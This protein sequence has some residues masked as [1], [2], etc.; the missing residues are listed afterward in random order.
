MDNH[1]INMHIAAM[2]AAL[3]AGGLRLT[4]SDDAD[5][6]K[7]Y[8][9]ANVENYPVS[10]PLD[11]ARVKMR[12]GFIW[13]RA[14]DKRGFVALECA[15]QIKAPAKRGGLAALLD[16]TTF[17]GR[18]PL[19]TFS[20]PLPVPLAGRLLYLGGAI[21]RPKLRDNGIMSILYRL[22]LAHGCRLFD[23]DACFGWVR[24]PHVGRAMRANGYGFGGCYE[25]PGTYFQSVRPE[26]LYLVYT[27]RRSLDARFAAAPAYSLRDG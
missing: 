18:G 5:E 20:V 27:L 1:A 8:A 12:D 6:Y 17:F 4:L 9:A 19:Q 3:E 7:A 16:D 23:P 24:E 14:E 13:I 22:V 25:M 26:T 21:V 10:A 2:C 15:R 11:P